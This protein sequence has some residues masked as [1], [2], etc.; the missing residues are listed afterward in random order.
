MAY[1][2][3]WFRKERNKS[4]QR[5]VTLDFLGHRFG[6]PGPHAGPY[7]TCVLR[8]D[9]GESLQILLSLPEFERFAA[10]LPPHV[11]RLQAGRN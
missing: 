3:G 7:A 4:K 5:T 10:Q 9:E 2:Q 1:A 8:S 11:R 6:C